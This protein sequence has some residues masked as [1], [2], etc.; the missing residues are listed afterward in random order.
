MQYITRKTT[1]DAGHRVMNEKMKCFNIHG[2]TYICE[3]TFKF[4]D[5]ED[6]GYAVDFKEIK[7]VGCQFID[8]YFDHAFIANPEDKEMIKVNKKLGSKI[9]IMGLNG[10]GYCNP[11]AE[12]IS[13]ELFL[14]LHILFL[15]Y[16]LLEIHKLRLWETPNCSVECYNTSFKDFEEVNFLGEH[17]DFINNYATKKGIINYDDRKDNK[18]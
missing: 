1:F 15:G 4:Y 6:I 14:S 13:K 5:M 7:R 12:N 10:N 3:L 17:F 2:H 9:W 11:T 8:D 18:S 16:P